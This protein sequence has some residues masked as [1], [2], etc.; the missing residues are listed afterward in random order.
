MI[1]HHQNLW[2]QEMK[3][4][5][6]VLFPR[7]IWVTPDILK[8]KNEWSPRTFL[9]STAFFPLSLLSSLKQLIPLHG[10]GLGEPCLPRRL[11]L[12]ALTACLGQAHQWWHAHSRARGN[13]DTLTLEQGA[14]KFQ[15]PSLFWEVGMA[16][17][18]W[19][20]GSAVCYNPRLLCD[21]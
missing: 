11:L 9:F 3:S 1:W 8:A 16:S 14:C 15:L 6:E 10:R 2:Q 21:I 19:A 20:W 17:A 7:G 5:R 13:G 12:A 18:S 4:T